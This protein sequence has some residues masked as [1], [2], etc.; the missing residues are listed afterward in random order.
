MASS[1][2]DRAACQITGVRASAS[3]SDRDQD[4]IVGC[5][6]ESCCSAQ[7]REIGAGADRQDSERHT[8]EHDPSSQV[9]GSSGHSTGQGTEGCQ[10]EQALLDYLAYAGTHNGS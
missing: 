10:S 6:L 4:L 8:D 2:A 7:D 3:T 1:P 9:G 5:S